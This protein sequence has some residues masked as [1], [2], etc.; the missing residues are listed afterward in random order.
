VA[1]VEDQTRT[2]TIALVAAA[3]ASRSTARSAWNITLQADFF[4]KIINETIF[5]MKASQY[6][7]F[8]PYEGGIVGYNSLKDDFIFLSN[9]LY[10]LFQELSNDITK[11]KTLHIDFWKTLI[12]KHFVVSNDID[13]LQ[14][15]KNLVYSIDHNPEYYELFI[16]PTLNCNFKCWY[17]YETHI[18]GSKM[19]KETIGKVKKH[20]AS[21]LNCKDIKQFNISWF[22]GEPLL[23]YK[24]VVIPILEF[25]NECISNKEVLFNSHFTSNGFL[26]TEHMMEELYL[27]GVR[28]FQI[29]LDGHREQH[30]KVRFTGHNNGSYDAL[31]SNI[32]KC[33]KS[34][35]HTTCRI[36]ISKDTFQDAERIIDDFSDLSSIDKKFLSFSFQQVWQEKTNLYAKILEL[37]ELFRKRHFS[38]SHAPHLDSVRNPCYADKSHQAII[39]YNG[40]VF[41]CTARDF[42]SENREGILKDDGSIIWNEKYHNRMNAKFKNPSCLVCRILPICN[43][44]CSQKAIERKDISYCMH[45]FDENKKIEVVRAKLEY[46]LS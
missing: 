27:L 20:I 7:I 16:N 5:I 28:N 17:C 42:I 15:V 24:E 10:S 1:V 44:A 35:I 36:N 25:T 11:L 6:N 43:G 12:D 9:E 8:F 23:Y 33:L 14:Q 34:K 31:V 46:T 45:D 4:D 22:G 30:N 32:K 39:N 19:R 26:I 2:L 37:T 21:K 40:D 18:R 38:I 3:A 13:E 41:K 29:T